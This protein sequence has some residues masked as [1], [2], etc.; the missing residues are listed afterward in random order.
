MF[1]LDKLKSLQGDEDKNVSDQED[2]WW[3]HIVDG[4]GWFVSKTT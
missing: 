1:I 3:P 4:I 2:E